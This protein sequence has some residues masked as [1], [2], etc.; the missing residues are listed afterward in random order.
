[1]IRSAPRN[2]MSDTASAFPSSSICGPTDGV[3]PKP[4]SFSVQPRDTELWI[5]TERKVTQ[6]G[7][8][9]TC[10][11]ATKRSPPT[12]HMVARERRPDR[13][14]SMF[15]TQP[16]GLRL[17][18]VNLLQASRPSPSEPSGEASIAIWLKPRMGITRLNSFRD[19]NISDP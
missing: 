11:H 6:A 16:A 13:S 15:E 14:P 9:Q 10:T 7:P 17:D 5:G 19:Q 4:T 3:P 12:S 18:V 1:M 2:N 8:P